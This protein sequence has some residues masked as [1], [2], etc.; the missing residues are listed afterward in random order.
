MRLE[1]VPPAVVLSVSVPTDVENDE[2]AA[3][4]I[5]IPPAVALISTASEPVPEELMMTEESVAP[6]T[7]IV[8]S[9]PAAPEASVKFMSSAPSIEIVPVESTVM[10]PVPASISIPPAA[11]EALM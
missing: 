4:S 9:S 6:V 2:A 7:A 11:F 5:S 1:D 10:P 8:K 3:A